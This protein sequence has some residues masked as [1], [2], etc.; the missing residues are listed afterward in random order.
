LDSRGSPGSFVSDKKAVEAAI[1]TEPEHLTGDGKLHPT[2][3]S[4]MKEKKQVGQKKA[5]TVAAGIM[6]QIMQAQQKAAEEAQAGSGGGSSS[7]G[8]VVN[9][10]PPPAKRQRKRR[11]NN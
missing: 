10:A 7:S 9:V 5:P 11:G 2:I 8:S 3:Q 6:G 4:R 1:P